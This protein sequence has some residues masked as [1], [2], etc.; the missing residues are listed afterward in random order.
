MNTTQRFHY[1]SALFLSG[2]TISVSGFVGVIFL[3]EGPKALGVFLISCAIIYATYVVG[4]LL[5]TDP[6]YEL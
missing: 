3:I 6:R 5:T 2:V 1:A 4:T